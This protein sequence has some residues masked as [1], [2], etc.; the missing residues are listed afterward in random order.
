MYVFITTEEQLSENTQIYIID[1]ITEMRNKVQRF[2]N[3]LTDFSSQFGN[4]LSTAIQNALL[5]FQNSIMSFI[6]HLH[7]TING[8]IKLKN[9]LQDK[10]YI[11]E[12]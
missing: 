2:F 5:D 3:L 7:S 6:A 12:H 1:D 10:K 9:V 8:E 4:Q 11:I